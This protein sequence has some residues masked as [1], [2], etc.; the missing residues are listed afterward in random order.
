MNPNPTELA[1]DNE[2]DSKSRDREQSRWL[3]RLGRQGGR[4]MVVAIAAPVLAGALLVV[5]AWLV[6]SVLGQAISYNAGRAALAN[7]IAL[8]ALIFVARAGLAYL[9]E[10]SGSAA[11]EGVIQ[12]VRLALFRKIMRSRPDWSGERASGAVSAAIVDQTEALEGFLGRFLPALIQATLLPVA[13]AVVVIPIDWVAGLLLFMTAPLIPLFMALAGWGAEAAKRSEAVAFARLSAYFADRLRGILTLRLFG[14]AQDETRAVENAS[15]RLR[16]S[17]M[18]VLRIAFLSSAVLEFFAALGVAGTALYIGLTFLGMVDLRGEMLTLQAGLFCLLM[19]PEVY[20]PLRLLAAHYHDRAGAKA[21]IAEID[22]LFEGL[23][24]LGGNAAPATVDGGQARGAADI[25]ATGLTVRAPGRAGAVLDGVSLRVS[26]GEHVA[27]VGES[28]SGKSTLLEAIARLRSHE[29]T[30]AIGGD[31]AVPEPIL[32]ERLAFLG[33]RPRLFH[34]TVADNIRLG[35][36]DASDEEVRAAGERAGLIDFSDLLPLG[37]ATPIGEGGLGISGG[38]A[39]R[40]AL[41]RIYLRDPEIVILD[42]PTAHLDAA[43]EARVI[44]GMLDFA[45]GR[46]LVVATHSRA[47]ASRMGRSLRVAGGQLLPVLDGRKDRAVQS[48]DVA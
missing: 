20:Q 39:H 41:A 35:R 31:I 32:R 44:D 18:R 14:R 45:A 8:I 16:E 1:V 36:H 38:E 24:D 26:A 43:M 7:S 29:G 37:L 11:A 10:S 27:I 6:A 22:A 9:A 40:V 33:Q 3:S 15:E 30:I 5:Q 21:T 13:F 28:G 47:L 46:T 12:R 19:A 25:V 48:G 4:A 17:T 23:P 34:G 42:E 2:G